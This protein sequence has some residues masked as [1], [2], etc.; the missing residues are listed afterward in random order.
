MSG[1]MNTGKVL[2]VKEFRASGTWVNPGVKT[3]ELFQVGGGGSGVGAGNVGQG[4]HVLSC[5][6][7]VDGIASCAVVIG[8]GGTSGGN[9]GNTSFDG[10]VIAGGGRGG[11]AQAGN[12]ALLLGVDGFGGHGASGGYSGNGAI[13]GAVG[14]ANTGAGGSSGFSGG[15]GYLRVEWYE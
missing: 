1:L 2:R 4:G 8:A 7:D 6:Y 3:V 9:G 12:I 5:K 10:V 14:V 15:S 13:Q 11:Q